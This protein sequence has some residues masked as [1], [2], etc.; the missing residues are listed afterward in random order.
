MNIEKELLKALC[1]IPLIKD[2]KSG[3]SELQSFHSDVKI[4]H[5]MLNEINLYPNNY[6]RYLAEWKIFIKLRNQ[7]N[8]IPHCDSKNNYDLLFKPNQK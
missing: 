6:K 3:V 5:K 8:F 1:D 7:E 4:L 2:G